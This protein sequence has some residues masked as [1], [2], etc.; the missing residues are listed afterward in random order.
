MDSWSF[1]HLIY[2][3]MYSC[4]NEICYKVFSSRKNVLS[5]F[6]WLP[7]EKKVIIVNWFLFLKNSINLCSP[8]LDIRKKGVPLKCES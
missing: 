6:I 2:A 8:K 1:V 7:L 5:Q 3:S 4:Q